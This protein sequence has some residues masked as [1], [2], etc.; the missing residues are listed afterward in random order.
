MAFNSATGQLSGTPGVGG[1]FSITISASN[2]AGSV[3]QSFTLTV[4][5]APAITSA[6]NAA[7]TA[8]MA[9][10]FTVTG[11]GFPTPSLTETRALPGGVSFQDNHNGTGTLSGTPASSGTFAISFA[12][13][14]SVG[15]SAVQTFTLT[16]TSAAS[17]ST[18]TVTPTT[19]NFGSLR[20]LHLGSSQVTLQNAGKSAI[21]INS[22]SL[23]YGPHTL[24][25]DFF[26][27]SSCKPSLAAGKSC[28][29]DVFYFADD[30]GT[31]TATLNI[32]DSASNSPQT[33]SLT[34]T[35]IK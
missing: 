4:N 16:V 14:N 1:T 5:Q 13:A 26:F 18:L 12:A 3:S 10:S 27:L 8:G 19:I 17:G 15:S 25:A 20:F 22:I 30:L 9:G 32:K 11:T 2:S 29:I 28:V 21:T 35:A 7:F 31:H 6:N 33:V 34:G 23:T 24:L